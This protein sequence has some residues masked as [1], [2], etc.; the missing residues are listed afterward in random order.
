ME[1]RVL[2][3]E[4]LKAWG[5]REQKQQEFEAEIGV[6]CFCCFVLVF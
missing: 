3:I 4:D 5:Q 6:A 1:C 2:S